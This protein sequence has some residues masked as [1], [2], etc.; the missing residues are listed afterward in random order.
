MA[1]LVFV[2]PQ[3]PLLTRLVRCVLVSFAIAPSLHQLILVVTPDF[4]EPVYTPGALPCERIA[5]GTRCWTLTLHS[6]VLLAGS[7]KPEVLVRLLE[8]LL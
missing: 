1:L 6:Y 5:A 4:L 8:S 7:K 3:V 2:R